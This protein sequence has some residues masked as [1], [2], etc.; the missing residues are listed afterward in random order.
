MF[1]NKFHIYNYIKSLV[2]LVENVVKNK[3]I[4][5]KLFCSKI[6]LIYKER[7]NIFYF[8]YRSY[9]N[10]N[11]FTLCVKLDILVSLLK[12]LS[13][14]EL[15]F[16]KLSDNK[17]LIKNNN[18]KFLFNKYSENNL[19]FNILFLFNKLT[20]FKILSN[21]LL[22]SLI[23]LLPI[24]K[25]SKN[26]NLLFLN[27]IFYNYRIE[28]IVTDGFRINKCYIFP[29]FCLNFL[30]IYKFSLNKSKVI[31]LIELLKIC[32]SKY[33]Y[34][35]INNNIFFIRFFNFIYYT[36]DIFEF[37]YNYPIYFSKGIC[38]F[39]LNRKKLLDSIKRITFLFSKFNNEIE[40]KFYRN[41]IKLFYFRN[42]Y[43]KSILTLSSFCYLKLSK[44]IKNTIKLNSKFLLDFLNS[45][46]SKNVYLYYKSFCKDLMLVF[47][48][49]FI[50]L[51]MPIL[52]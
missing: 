11:D 20:K 19:N 7:N 17:L 23:F 10:I 25:I 50:S 45:S 28:F 43:E 37:N 1:L 29:F 32:N 49:N 33:I 9:V 27:L 26:S 5:I 4:Y 8:F 42:L 40:I 46:S 13:N 41:Y 12:N 38:K 2:Y 3:K 36:N 21:E 35:Y 24:L 15:L 18:F 44:Y 6:Y 52:Y 48:N 51:I 39:K 47:D 22:N 31:F 14:F 30:K 16:N 34:L